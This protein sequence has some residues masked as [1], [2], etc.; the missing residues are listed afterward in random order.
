M[1]RWRADSGG[2]DDPEAALLLGALFSN[3]LV[4]PTYYMIP[5]EAKSSLLD[6][7]DYLFTQSTEVVI[8]FDV[9]LSSA[10]SGGDLTAVLTDRSV[11]TFALLAEKGHRLPAAW[12]VAVFTQAFRLFRSCLL[13][14]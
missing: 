13:S 4:G 7:L 11:Q 5:A 1:R 14:V 9:L 3:L 6:L 8:N 12:L 10:Q 2:R